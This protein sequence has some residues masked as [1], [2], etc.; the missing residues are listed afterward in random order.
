ML[1]G[2]NWNSF[3]NK[4]SSNTACPI[5][6]LHGCNFA[7]CL[8]CLFSRLEWADRMTGARPSYPLEARELYD[9]RVR[10]ERAGADRRA[11]PHAVA[12]SA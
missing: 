7:G 10:G 2:L 6:K 12:R 5:D 8:K 3:H 11:E 4:N 1:N 9:G